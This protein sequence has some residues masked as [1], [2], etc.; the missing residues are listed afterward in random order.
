VLTVE[1]VQRLFAEENIEPAWK[2]HLLYRC[3]N[4]VAACT[5]CR[6]GELLALRD[7]AV[8]PGW[9]HIAHSYAPAYGLGPTKTH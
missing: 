9:L 8:H 7:D 3:I 4:L 1:E 5:G 6:Q 2:G